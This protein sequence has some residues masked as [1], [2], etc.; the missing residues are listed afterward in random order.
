[1]VK[2]ARKGSYIALLALGQTPD[3]AA[4]KVIELLDSSDPKFV[5]KVQEALYLR[6]PDPLLQSKL[7]T[8]QFLR[9]GN[10]R[11]THLFARP[12]VEARICGGRA[13]TR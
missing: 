13:Q 1:M 5:N 6:M 3:P 10:W 2:R 11:S 4:S 9:H 12:I 8:R 7:H